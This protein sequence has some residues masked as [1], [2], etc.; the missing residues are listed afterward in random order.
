MTHTAAPSKSSRPL[1]VELSFVVVVIALSV[2]GFWKVFFGV[3]AE[4][5]GYQ[6]LH[7]VTNFA[8]LLLLAWQIRL[9]RNSD[10]GRHRQAGLTALVLAPLLVGSAAL[11]SVHSAHAGLISGA[12]DF[13]IVQ[14]VMVTLELGLVILLAFAMRRRRR[15]HGAFLLSS[16]LLFM[17]IALFF[18]LIS[19]VPGFRIEGPETL[20]RFATAGMAAQGAA[21][22]VGGLFFL[23]DW[24]NGWPMLMAGAFFTFNEGLRVFLASSDLITP[25]TQLVGSLSQPLTFLACTVVMFALLVTT[26]VLRTAREPRARGVAGGP[27]ADPLG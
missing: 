14:N 12:G 7:A 4:P 2:A 8:W 15:L 21:L 5:D 10:F 23:R 18:T 6:L 13:L 25:L 16:A 24:R 9:V 11:L 27:L 20:H 19:F 1:T 3:D 17:G 26:G 22:A